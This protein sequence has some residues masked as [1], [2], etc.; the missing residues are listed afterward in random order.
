MALEKIDQEKKSKEIRAIFKWFLNFT[1]FAGITQSRDSDNSISRWAWFC[2]G[3]VGYCLTSY[4]AVQ[5]IS[6]FFEYPSYT[7]V[8]FETGTAFKTARNFPS[9]T[10]YNRN[11]M[12]CGHLYDLIQNC[13]AVM[14]HFSFYCNVKACYWK[15]LKYW[16][17]QKR[18]YVFL[19]YLEKQNL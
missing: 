3:L 18:L 6:S 11:R 10:I 16:V 7:N 9:V 2:L 1:S 19:L 13:T 5:T 8:F 17:R 4:S 15:L 12:H 14:Y